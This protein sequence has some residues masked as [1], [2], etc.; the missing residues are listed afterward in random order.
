[1]PHRTDGLYRRSHRAQFFFKYKNDDGTWKEKATGMD[2]YN[3]ARKFR[4]NFLF[5]LEQGRLPNERAKWS[6]A[7]A[8]E[9]WLKERKLRTSSGTYSSEKTSTKNLLRA[10]KPETRLL[11]LADVGKVR[12]YE[13]F[14]LNEGI[15]PKTVNNETL[16]LAGILK[17]AKLWHRIEDDYKRLPV[18]DSDI[19]DTLTHE[20]SQRLLKMARLAH[21]DAVVPYCAVL[22]FATG[23]R[24]KEIKHLQL[25][26]INLN[27]ERS[28]LQVKRTTTK[29]N[30]GAR[31]VAL[32][33][34]ACWAIGKLLSRAK[35][36]GATEPEHYLL[37]TRLDRH[38]RANDP[39][40][41]VAIDTGWDVNHAQSSWEKEWKT[42]RKLV[43]I[44][45][46]RFHDLR[47]SFITRAA[48]AGVAIQVIQAQVGHMSQAMVEYYCHISQAAVHKAAELMERQNPELLADL[49]IGG[50]QLTIA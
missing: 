21:E 13:N 15:S 38:T 43:K 29:T 34:M 27:P 25:N 23:M 16:I 47:H 17:R 22:A 19:G 40:H 1:M 3:K 10:L 18:K 31:F 7:Q 5:E 11:K 12:A 9:D 44:E 35:R 49:G 42:F 28:Q 8:V 6:L 24:S 26:S 39:L 36:L 48:E 37:P 33:K 46:R 30:K 4:S 20:E 45:H 41:G 32:D 14:R 2:D 50:E